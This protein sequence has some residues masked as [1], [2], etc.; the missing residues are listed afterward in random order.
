[1]IIN[2]KSSIDFKTVYDIDETQHPD[3]EDIL[4]GQN[5]VRLGDIRK[6]FNDIDDSRSVPMMIMY[7]DM[8]QYTSLGLLD[9]LFD[10]HK[11]DSNIPIKAFMERKTSGLDFVKSICKVWN[12][13]PEEVDH[14]FKTY[15]A[16]V[17]R[18]SPLSR[19]AESIIKA[20]PMSSSQLFVFKYYVPGIKEAILDAIQTYGSRNKED[21]SIPTMFDF[22]NDRTEYDYYKKIPKTRLDFFK[23]VFTANAGDAMKVIDERKI[24]VGANVFTTLKHNG[25]DEDQLTT[26]YINRGM[27][28]GDY[29]INFIEEGI[30]L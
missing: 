27:G 10:I 13:S 16:E 17:L 28:N 11:I 15:Y 5:K 21:I 25:L 1:M 12:I 29:M 7:D 8:Y 24:D 3:N 2:D 4:C 30:A 9:L 23:C 6:F 22:L 26:I 19:N 14:T 20:R 18:R